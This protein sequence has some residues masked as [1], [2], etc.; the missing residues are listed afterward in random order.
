MLERIGQVVLALVMRPATARSYRARSVA[1][2]I[3]AGCL[4]GT[5]LIPA[6]ALAKKSFKE[7][8]SLLELIQ[9]MVEDDQD[10]AAT[11]RAAAAPRPSAV[12]AAP[13]RNSRSSALEPRGFT[14]AVPPRAG[15]AEPGSALSREPRLPGSAAAPRP[16]Q[17]ARVEPQQVAQARDPERGETVLERPRPELDPIGQRVG[18][19]LVYPSFTLAGEVDDNIFRDDS[20][21]KTDFITKLRPRLRVRSDWSRHALT[22][23]A[24]ADIGIY[25]DNNSENYEDARIGTAGRLDI[26][27]D[28]FAAGGLNFQKLHEDRGSPD[29]AGGRNPTEFN[30]L[31][32]NAEL[33]RQFGRFNGT[34]NAEAKGIDFNDADAFIGGVVTEINND[35]RDRTIVTAAGRVGYEIFRTT[36][37]SYAAKGTGGSTTAP[38]TMPASTETPSASP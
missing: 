33:F 30:V 31:T 17:L 20:G 8:S 32:G 13:S 14:D 35:D 19:F 7:V 6:P 28:T 34:I 11:K 1:A 2:L 10:E 22:F 12:P 36:R 24:D 21:T 37:P 5:T 29:E 18:R 9:L 3:F 16:E 4:A 25:Y 23:E 27:G 15:R 38:P 26:D